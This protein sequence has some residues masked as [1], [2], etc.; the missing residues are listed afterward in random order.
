MAQE[1]NKD[2]ELSW[3][4]VRSGAAKT[5]ATSLYDAALAPL[6]PFL[7]PIQ[8]ATTFKELGK[9]VVSKA[10][11]LAGVPQSASEKASNEA[12][13]NSIGSYYSDRYGSMKGLKKALASDPAG[14][15]ADVAGVFTLG[16]GLAVRAPGMIGKAARVANKASMLADPTNILGNVAVRAPTALYAG[17]SMLKGPALSGVNWRDVSEARKAGL[18]KTPE[19]NAARTG[20]MTDKAIVDMADAALNKL[21]AARNV[22]YQNDRGFIHANTTP[23]SYN[24]IEDTI[25][26]LRAANTSS[27][28]LPKNLAAEK[29]LNHLDAEVAGWKRAG[30]VT[31]GDFDDLKQ[32]ISTTSAKK[33]A[34]RKPSWDQAVTTQ[35]LGSIRD[36]IDTQVPLYRKYMGDYGDASDIIND[37]KTSLSL[38]DKASYANGMSRLQ[39]AFKGKKGSGSL[40]D[41]S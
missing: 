34:A 13:I 26:R 31:A 39:T 7:H 30:H 37:M 3:S 14:V 4:E 5:G 12:V 38:G 20:K 1:K 28:G 17:S 27:G 40:D 16:T 6:Q 36:T 8:T 24:H 2:R 29:T 41:L 23:I 25:A 35:V 33:L 15:V 11:G 10:I 21:R 22:K 18:N 19:F 32:R 9:G